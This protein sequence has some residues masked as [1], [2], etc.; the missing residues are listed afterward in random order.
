M[1]LMLEEVS[2]APAGAVRPNPDRSGE[3]AV[4][5]S[6]P[7][8]VGGNTVTLSD[9]ID[10]QVGTFDLGLC[11][12]FISY[13]RAW[14]GRRTRS[15]GPQNPFRSWDCWFLKNKF[16]RWKDMKQNTGFAAHLLYHL[17]NVAQK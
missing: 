7:D 9:L 5:L 15:I 6:A 13:A 3:V 1:A 16:E 8:A 12:H 11:R 17:R 10:V 14:R 4:P 2:H